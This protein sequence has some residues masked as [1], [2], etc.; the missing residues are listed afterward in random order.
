[1]ANLTNC[2]PMGK[3]TE[4][5]WANDNDR[6]RQFHRTWNVDNPSSGY[7]DIGS[8]S[9]AAARLAARPDRDDNTLPA[10]RAEG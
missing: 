4:G 1:M 2:W 6:P 3:A 5:K 8:A 9:L 10:R 7:R